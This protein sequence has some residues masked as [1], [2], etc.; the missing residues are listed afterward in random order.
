M[1]TPPVNASTPS[2]APASTG[3]TSRQRTNG[4]PRPRLG[5]DALFAS[6]TSTRATG[7]TR[8]RASGAAP[9]TP[10]TTPAPEAPQRASRASA[11]R[12][13][14]HLDA[15]V[16]NVAS[17]SEVVRASGAAKLSV[18]EKR[19]QIALAKEILAAARD[20]KT[21]VFIE[22]ELLKGLSMRGV[23]MV[24]VYVVAA[25]LCGASLNPAPILMAM[26]MQLQIELLPAAMADFRAFIRSKCHTISEQ[27]E[28]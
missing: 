8:V 26:G 4:T 9:S 25:A 18:A 16:D 3:E 27:D 23:G 17:D 6:D 21:G 14:K 19:R 11:T 2:T 24:T 10:L 1:N 15:L 20:K 22:P 7:E 13:D 28:G 12:V 5:R